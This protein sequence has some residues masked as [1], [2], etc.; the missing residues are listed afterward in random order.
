M[1]QASP[2]DQ[3]G[4]SSPLER[5]RDKKT[6]ARGHCR[7]NNTGCSTGAAAAASGTA[8]SE[9]VVSLNGFKSE[10]GDL[11]NQVQHA[12]AGII[13]GYKY[14]WLFDEM[15]ELGH[16]LNDDNYFC[17]SNRIRRVRRKHLFYPMPNYIVD[18]IPKTTPHN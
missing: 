1:G 11:W 8:F 2:E 10:L 7:A 9:N 4:P 12:A 16:T 15:C 5:R 18:H 13:I 3:T 14:G 6:A 17:L